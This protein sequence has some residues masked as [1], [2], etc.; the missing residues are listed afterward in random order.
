MSSL[1]RKLYIRKCFF[2]IVQ[3]KLGTYFV[4][5]NCT[6]MKYLCV[7]LSLAE[8]CAPSRHITVQRSLNTTSR[9]THLPL[10]AAQVVLIISRERAGAR[11]KGGQAVA[12]QQVDD[13]GDGGYAHLGHVNVRG[14]QQQQHVRARVFGGTETETSQ[15]KNGFLPKMNNSY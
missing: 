7:Q 11:D 12:H 13:G 2:L 5:S 3:N 9:L 15:G 10:G 1:N 6:K 8:S 4:K 14:L